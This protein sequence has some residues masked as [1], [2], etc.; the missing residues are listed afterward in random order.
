MIG[1]TMILR[2]YLNGGYEMYMWHLVG[3]VSKWSMSACGQCQLGEI[4]GINII[5]LH[6]QRYFW[7]K[8]FSAMTL[9]SSST[10]I[11]VHVL[12]NM[13]TY[14]MR[15]RVADRKKAS[16]LSCLP[17][18]RGKKRP[19]GMST[20]KKKYFF[21]IRTWQKVQNSKYIMMLQLRWISKSCSFLS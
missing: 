6:L 2:V 13:T 9:S 18:L 12:I 7:T 5:S 3:P 20:S 15:K 10:F 19:K 11:L 4:Q 14:K 21:C 17:I 16:F 8:C 1:K